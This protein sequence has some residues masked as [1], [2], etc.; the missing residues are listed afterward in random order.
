MEEFAEFYD[1]PVT[2]TPYRGEASTGPTYA[3]PFTT[4]AMVTGAGGRTTIS[5]EGTQVNATAVVFLPGA[6]AGLLPGTKIATPDREFTA[7]EVHSW[8]T[9]GLPSTVEVVAL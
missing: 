2:V 5:R 1:T 6:H 8:A 4:Q 9:E 7:A 3:A